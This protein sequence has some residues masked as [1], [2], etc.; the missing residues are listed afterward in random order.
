MSVRLGTLSQPRGCSGRFTV[1]IN[2]S[3]KADADRARSPREVCS[4]RRRGPEKFPDL[5]TLTESF[6]KG[7]TKP[8]TAVDRLSLRQ[9]GKILS[10]WKP[11][12]PRIFSMEASHGSPNRRQSSFLSCRCSRSSQSA[13]PTTSPVGDSRVGVLCHHVW[14]AKSYSAIA[15]WAQDQDIGLMHRLGFTRKP[16]K[17]GGIRKVLIALRRKGLRGRS[18]PVGRIVA[19]P[20]SLKPAFATG[21]FRSR[22]QD[23][24]WQLRRPREGGPP[25]LLGSSRVG[26]NVGSDT[27]PQRRRKQDQRAQNSSSV[28]P[29]YRSRRTI[30]NRRRHVL[31]A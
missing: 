6:S 4:R 29:R 21:S 9:I 20:T 18:E 13:W 8:S 3:K 7:T 14:C 22:R 15:Q 2:A 31:P 28:A 11:P 27:G 1:T 10:V 26:V 23:S 5:S 25:A 17:M 12:T 16:P 30:G 24:S 19:G